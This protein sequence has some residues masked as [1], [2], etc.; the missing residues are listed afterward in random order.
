[1]QRLESQLVCESVWAAVAQAVREVVSL[2]AATPVESRS[3]WVPP[4]ARHT[5]RMAPAKSGASPGRVG[6]GGSSNSTA[7]APVPASRSDSNDS[8]HDDGSDAVSVADIP[9]AR[10]LGEAATANDGAGQFSTSALRLGTSL[11]N[12]ANRGEDTNAIEDEEVADNTSVCEV[13]SEDEAEVFAPPETDFRGR[14]FFLSPGSR[15]S[16]G[17]I[18]DET[19]GPIGSRPSTNSTGT[20][21]KDGVDAGMGDSER[22]RD[23]GL[24]MSRGAVS[25]CSAP[26]AAPTRL[27][28]KCARESRVHST[29]VTCS[30]L[31]RLPMGDGGGGGAGGGD[32]MLATG[33]IDGTVV[34]Q[35]VGDGTVI[36]VLKH[37]DDPSEAQGG[38]LGKSAPRDAKGAAEED[39]AAPATN[40]TAQD[41]SAD[42]TS[43]D[44]LPTAGG[45]AGTGGVR[46]RDRDRDREPSGVPVPVSAV[47]CIEG[48]NVV[49][50]GTDNGIV[51]VW[52]AVTGQCIRVLRGHTGAVK[53]FSLHVDKSAG[54]GAAGGPSAHIRTRGGVASSLRRFPS[55]SA[56]GHASGSGSSSGSGSAT[57][58]SGG[59]ASSESSSTGAGS[60]AQGFPSSL[61]GVKCVSGS[62]DLTLRVWALS[63]KRPLLH[64]LRG[65]TGAINMVTGIPGSAVVVSASADQTLRMWDL[66][67]GRPR[68]CMKVRILCLSF[69]CSLYLRL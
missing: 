25:V 27:V 2:P 48:T 65:H 41:G 15:G 46:E 63:H 3:L 57:G 52:D 53:C 12:F 6:S 66:L 30:L 44:G 7:T 68:Q 69:V 26:G 17:S 59:A 38:K 35:S 58:T 39:P 34:V 24:L 9:S 10:S 61:D 51:W 54:S 21:G 40:S 22:D 67:S 8:A 13:V 1:M 5:L 29:A 28:L 45:T 50:T 36:S 62:V 42:E 31:V 56:K 16:R 14:E 49:I 19:L 47:C 37:Y 64:V 55:G 23:G 33:S 20:F 43:L 18:V 11:Y 4:T 32:L 60:S